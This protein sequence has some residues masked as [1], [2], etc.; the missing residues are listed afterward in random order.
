M[1]QS[2]PE[3]RTKVFGSHGRKTTKLNKEIMGLY[4]KSKIPY[5]FKEWV[6]FV[7]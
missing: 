2:S 6:G 4:H 3:L 1:K 7:K 5:L